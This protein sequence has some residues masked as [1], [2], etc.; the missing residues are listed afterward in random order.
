M[1]VSRRPRAPQVLLLTKA[2]HENGLLERAE[3]VAGQ[4]LHVEDVDTLHLSQDLETLKTG[5]LLEVGGDG[6]DGGTFGLEVGLVVHFFELAVH[7][8]AGL[9][10]AGGELGLD[11]GGVGGFWR[12]WWLVGVISIGWDVMI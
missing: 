7:V 11:V 6:A 12:V 5:G 9:V 3:A 4:R 1:A 2:L 10:V 8:A